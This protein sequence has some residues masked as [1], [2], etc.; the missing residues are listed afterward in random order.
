MSG[1]SL[2][3]TE[4]VL[5]REIA[6][7]PIRTQRDLSQSAGLS[8]G[9]TNLLI[10]RLA[11]KGLIKVNQ[12]DWNRT[13]YLLTLKGALEKTRKMY[14]YTL[15]TIRIFRQIQ[16]N[17]ATILR[18]EYAAGRRRFWL[19]AQDE[20]KDL[21]REAAA[22]GEFPQASFT[23]LSRFEE[24]PREAD[25]VL[26]VTQEQPPKGPAGRRHLSLVDFDNIDFRLR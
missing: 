21:L 8:L 13:Q 16:E 22:G 23:L 7:S 24:V 15:Y 14:D 1:N 4:L 5:M 9:M 6:K 2:A 3:E 12:L 19:V 25:M 20:F 26:T 11:R 17:M 10:K 18:R